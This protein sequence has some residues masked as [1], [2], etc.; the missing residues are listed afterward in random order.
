MSDWEKFKDT[1]KQVEELERIKRFEEQE[2]LRIRADNLRKKE[3]QEQEQAKK[4]ALEYLKSGGD[5][6]KLFFQEKKPSSGSE[7]YQQTATSIEE[8]F[9]NPDSVWEKFRKA[10]I[11]GK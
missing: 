9:T 10:F 6:K 5:P 11:Q 8:A 1:E 4:Q 3:E 2:A 7:K